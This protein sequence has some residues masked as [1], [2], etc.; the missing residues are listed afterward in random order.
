[1]RPI[2]IVAGTRPEIIKLAPVHREFLKN[3]GR[4]VVRIST[5]R[6]ADLAE[7]TLK[8]FAIEPAVD[9]KATKPALCRT[10]SAA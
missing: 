3:G 10:A 8:A 4:Q 7:H 2:C 1:M 5:G 9:L 6:H